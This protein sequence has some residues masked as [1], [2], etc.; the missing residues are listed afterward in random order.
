M[1]RRLVQEAQHIAKVTGKRERR[2]G[3][4]VLFTQCTVG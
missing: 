1:S 4:G 3:E 2:E